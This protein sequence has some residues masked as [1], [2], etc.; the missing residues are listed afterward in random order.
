[1]RVFCQATTRRFFLWPLVLLGLAVFSMSY[2]ERVLKLWREGQRGLQPL[3]AAVPPAFEAVVL[4]VPDGATL[5]VRPRPFSTVPSRRIRLAYIDCPVYDREHPAA[6]QPFGRAA[7]EFTERLTLGA[8]VT[9][10]AI[11][12]DAGAGLVSHVRL[13]DGRDLTAELLSAGLAWWDGPAITDAP[14][15]AIEPLA[16]LQ[17]RGVWSDL[18]PEPPW[19]FRVRVDHP[20]ARLRAAQGGLP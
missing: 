12:A 13:P 15:A 1:M 19:G 17:R 2:D 6:A 7:T 14:Q 9:V 10:Q 8:T 11:A 5:T 4:S 3:L 20:S 16:R 18:H